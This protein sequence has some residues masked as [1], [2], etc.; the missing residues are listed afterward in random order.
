[1]SDAAEG[2]RALLLE[3]VLRIVEDAKRSSSVVRAGYHAG[4]LLA[5]YP[6]AGFSL[7]RII[8]EIVAA[9]AA[10]RVPVEISRDQ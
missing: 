1:M 2:A 9:A 6:K 10:A 4:Q 3:E 7:G 5:A 8:D